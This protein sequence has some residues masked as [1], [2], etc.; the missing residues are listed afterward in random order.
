MPL[1][2]LSF[3]KNYNLHYFLL[4]SNLMQS[5]TY[6]ISLEKLTANKKVILLVS[7]CR[8]GSTS[9]L[10]AFA[11][12]GLKSYLQ[13]IKNILR[14]STFAQQHHWQ[15]VNNSS[16]PIFIKETFGPFFYAETQ[17][18]PLAILLDCGFEKH[19]IHL[20]R[21]GRTPLETWVS[22][23]HYWHE[24]T[25]I[26]LF[27]RSYLQTNNVYQFA[28]KNNIKSSTLVYEAFH[29]QEDVSKVI[30]Q[31]CQTCAIKFKESSVSGWNKLPAFGEKDSNIIIPKMPDKYI[32]PNI[33]QRIEQGK[34]IHYYSR[35]EEIN[36][37]NPD[38]IKAIKDANLIEI[39]NQWLNSYQDEFFKDN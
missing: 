26:D 19:N 32:T 39:Y 37:L 20:L 11:A 1:N 36:N 9:I 35:A 15:P 22:W 7:P 23:K 17:F 6:A 14:W 2:F 18:N 27:I 4:S 38:E 12:L 24:K 25:S 29:H 5:D 30:Q 8:S 31:L 3:L 34:G 13:P 21:L 33:R 16:K 10:R 28:Q